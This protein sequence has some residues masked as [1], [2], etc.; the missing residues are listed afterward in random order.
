M[1]L[2]IDNLTKLLTENLKF[3]LDD[4]IEDYEIKKVLKFI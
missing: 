2:D 3:R 1:E 4:M